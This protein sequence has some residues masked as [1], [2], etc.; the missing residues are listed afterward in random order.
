MRRLQARL[1]EARGDAET[2]IELQAEAAAM[3]ATT[4]RPSLA[5]WR[6]VGQARDG[7]NRALKAAVL[8]CLI[9]PE[10]LLPAIRPRPETLRADPT[11]GRD[12]ASP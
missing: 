8:L 2:A 9:V 5:L 4:A 10:N 11:S 7:D 1:A 12:R 3:A 6:E